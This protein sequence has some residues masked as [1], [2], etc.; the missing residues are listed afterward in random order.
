MENSRRLADKNRK[1]GKKVEY[2]IPWLN[3]LY[4]LKLLKIINFNSIGCF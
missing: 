2:F 4:K 1:I 3:S